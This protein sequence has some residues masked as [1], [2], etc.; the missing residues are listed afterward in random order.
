VAGGGSY[1]GKP[2]PAVIVQ[3]DR[4]DTTESITICPIT[5]DPSDA[6]LFRLALSPSEENG[7]RSESR[8]M[9]DKIST[10]AKAKLGIR[11]GRLAQ[12]DIVRLNRAMVVF[13][14]VASR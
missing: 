5:T 1:A 11:I 14:G 3:D 4:I 13:L 12:E 8:I 2:R 10:V 7:L 9:V 6:P